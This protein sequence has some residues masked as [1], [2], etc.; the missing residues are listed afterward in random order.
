MRVIALC[1]LLFACQRAD[2]IVEPPVNADADTDTDTDADSDADTDTDTEPT[3]W[4]SSPTVDGDLS[5]F[6]AD[7]S[8]ATTSG[9]GTTYITWDETYLY[10]GTQNAN[11]ATG[12]DQHWFR[13]LIGNPAFD[14]EPVGVLFGSQQPTLPFAGTHMVAWKADDSFIGLWES[15]AGSWV[16]ATPLTSVPG[17]AWGERN[18]LQSFE[19]RVP[20]AVFGPGRVYYIHTDWIFEG[21]GFE[22]TFAGTP[23]TSFI[24]G[25]NPDFSNY[26]VIDRDAAGA[27]VTSEVR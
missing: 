15:D 25:F 8:F 23:A 4:S 10:V 21:A 13:V 22:S 17:T 1:T 16:G 18:D 9:D 11:V 27:P 2:D 14:G 7:E 12:T 3:P 6:S 24:D 20:F 5:D 26:I 19:V